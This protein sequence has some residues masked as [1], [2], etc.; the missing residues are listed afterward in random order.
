MKKYLWVCGLLL[1]VSFFVTYQYEKRA[2]DAGTAD[3][4]GQLPAV[5]ANDAPEPRAYS[6]QA[7]RNSPGWNFAHLVFGW[8]NGVTVWAVLVTLVV[9]AEQTHETRR[10]A[11]ATSIAAENAMVQSE[12]SRKTL[13]QQYR[14]KLIVRGCVPLKGKLSLVI[15]NTGGTPAYLTELLFSL[16]VLDGT[17]PVAGFASQ[18]PAEVRFAPGEMLSHFIE[19]EPEI[20]RAI[21]AKDKALT[22]GAVEDSILCIALLRYRDDLGINR[23]TGISRAYDARFAKFVPVQWSAEDEYAD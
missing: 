7:N 10:A 15:V 9:I 12:L 1:F 17:P 5:A 13:I 8:P 22:L 16:K 19:F 11:N 4:R 6:K 23:V 18:L 21:Q 20:M 14:P 2:H 3:R